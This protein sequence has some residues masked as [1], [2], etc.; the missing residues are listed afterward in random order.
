MAVSK[1]LA[2]DLATTTQWESK[3]LEESKSM[4]KIIVYNVIALDGYHPGLDNDNILVRYEVLH[5]SA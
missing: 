3:K 4:R 2:S 1:P 5:K